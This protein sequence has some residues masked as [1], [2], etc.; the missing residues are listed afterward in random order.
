MR[1]CKRIKKWQDRILD[2]DYHKADLNKVTAEAVHLVPAEQKR[3]N[4]LLKRYEYLFDGNLG[5]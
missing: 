2:A 4:F 5:Q 1:I 3:L